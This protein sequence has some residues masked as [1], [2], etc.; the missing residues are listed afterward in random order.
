MDRQILGIAIFSVGYRPR[1]I[2]M[3]NFMSPPLL[4]EPQNFDMSVS[5]RVRPI[6]LLYISFHLEN[7]LI[8]KS[9]ITIT[10]KS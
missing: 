2:T 6:D 1:P 10:V 8:L 4:E 5:Q 7:R 3:Q 9:I